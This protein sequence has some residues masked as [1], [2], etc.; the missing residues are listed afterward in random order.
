MKEVMERIIV[1][2]AILVNEII[3]KM[4]RRRLTLAYK[5]LKLVIIYS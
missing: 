2:N 3:F 1:R 5:L 4:E